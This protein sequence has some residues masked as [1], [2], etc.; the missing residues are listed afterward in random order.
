MLQSPP[1]RQPSF[2]V[3]YELWLSSWETA[4]AALATASQ[5]RAL[6]T[7]HAAAL[8]ALIVDERRFVTR[9]FTLLLG[10]ERENSSSRGL[11][12]FPSR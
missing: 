7:H 4:L 1:E 5:A 8:K 6:S 11:Q 12:Y 10:A 9:E 3:A 2:P